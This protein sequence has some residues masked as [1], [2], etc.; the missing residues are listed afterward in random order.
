MYSLSTRTRMHV[1]KKFECIIHALHF[2]KARVI[3]ASRGGLGDSRSIVL[4]VRKHFKLQQ[5]P[6][7]EPTRHPGPPL[8]THAAPRARAP[9]RIHADP[10]PLYEPAL[11][12]G[13]WVRPKGRR[14]GEEPELSLLG[15][16]DFLEPTC[17]WILTWP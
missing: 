5:R 11:S 9:L 14:L 1:K 12:A 16:T 2:T 6:L 13:L 17:S 15:F 4:Q 10:G 7:H 8:R 3:Q